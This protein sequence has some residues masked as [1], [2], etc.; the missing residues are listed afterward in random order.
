MV[1]ALSKLLDRVRK[2][3]CMMQCPRDRVPGSPQ[4]ICKILFRRG[5]SSKLFTSGVASLHQN[6]IV[7][8][9]CMECWLPGG[10]PRTSFL[11]AMTR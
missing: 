7:Q 10:L 2:R 5:L 9:R 4:T 3:T 1:D 11:V 8:N 6:E